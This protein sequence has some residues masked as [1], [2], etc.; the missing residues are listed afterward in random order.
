MPEAK[1]KGLYAKLAEVMGEVGYVQKRGRNTFHNY[2]YVTEADL[3]DAV[4]D[5]LAAR[6]IMI[7]PS[8]KEL[9]ERT[10]ATKK[11]ESTISTVLMDF[12]FVDGD[13]GEQHTVTMVGQ[14]EDAADKGIYKALTGA[15]KYFVMKAFLVPTGDDP[16]ADTRTDQRAQDRTAPPVQQVPPAPLA[17][18]KIKKVVDA[19]TQAGVTPEE[20][21]LHLTSVGIDDATQM[22]AVHAR[23]LKKVLDSLTPA[24]A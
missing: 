8:I 15:A 12:T 17:P 11:G 2:D 9:Q 1:P 20:F 22:T 23:A 6:N 10:I 7:L 3:L 5:K 13:S 14:G 24:A 19:F 18:D 21:E 4:R 16:E